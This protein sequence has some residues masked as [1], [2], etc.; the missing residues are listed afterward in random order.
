ML[1]ATVGY[2]DQIYGG[3]RSSLAELMGDRY[4]KI[5]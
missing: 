5:C 1:N 4:V 3:V 2:E